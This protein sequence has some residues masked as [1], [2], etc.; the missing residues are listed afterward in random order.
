MDT[1]IVTSLGAGS[2]IDITKL[3]SQLVEVERAPQE[4]RI[5]TRE[6][7]LQ[8][9]ISG[10]GQLKS[11]LDTLKTAI[12]AL[13]SKDLFNARSVAVPTSEAITADKVSPG[14]QTGS[15]KIKV[16]GVASA[17]SLA[18]AAQDERDSA[19]NAAGNMTISFGEWSYS[20]TPATTPSGFAVNDDRAS[21]SISVAATDSLDSI[22]AKINAQD[23]GVQAS[24]LKVDDRYQLMLTSP[25]GKNNAMQ[26]SVDD[27]S[28]NGFAFTTT[29]HAQ[30][31]E[32][33]QA[34]NAEIEVN[35]LTVT[36]ENNSIDDVISGF[37]FT[38]N[39]VSTESLSFAVTADRDAAEDAVRGFI[40]AYND[41]QKTSQKLVGYTRDEDNNLVRGELAGDSSAR[42]TINRLREMI[43]SAVPGLESGF[44]ALTNIGVRTERDGSVSI[45]EDEFSSAI[46]NN[47]NLVAELF[48]SKTTSAN[49]AVTVNPGTFSAKAV[50]GNY[51]VEIAMDPTHG[52]TLGTTLSHADFDPVTATFNTPLT[53]SGAD[54]RFQINV[55]GA[56]S[57][58]IELSGTYA[59]AEELRADLQSRINGDS[60]LKAA[61]VGLDVGFDTAT[62]RFSFT[63]REYGTASQVRFTATGT[64]LTALG[65]APTQA[66]IVGSA[67]TQSGFD[68]PTESFATP[69]DAAAGDY[70]FKIR[71]DGVTSDTL[72]LTGT[73]DT[74]EEL[75]AGL[76]T[77]IN[78]DAK[79]AAAGAALD[80]DYDATT[81]RFSFVSRTGGAT[82]A[83]G[84]TETGADM[85]QLGV[86]LAMTGTHGVDVAGT[87]DGVAGFGA[88][89]VLLPDI[90]SRAYGLNLQVN[91]GAKAQ[92][93]AAGADGFQIGFSRGFAGELS[94]LIEGF[95]GTSGTINTREE[96]IQSQLDGLD[97]ERTQLD[98]RMSGVS[99]RLTAQ[100]VAM[101]R[102]VDSLQG[103]GS[104]LE[105][106]VDR[107]PFTAS[108]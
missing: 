94:K 75:R 106:L 108:T 59:S 33:Q 66:R 64:G 17:Q 54:Y 60:K 90:A 23:A 71:V 45:D 68:A 95:L 63:S 79:L 6:E 85:E 87:I 24:V 25:S 11:S 37:A 41:F 65:L 3:V 83:V 103:T 57:E 51:A 40:S 5:G 67:L 31:T 80:V 20:G 46:K 39:K 43:G 72:E 1:N 62:N 2:G 73:Y 102:I 55:D 44:T 38:V 86:A 84:F 48:A 30:V 27:A 69:F 98:R 78:G 9:Q 76:E 35:G 91:P 18:T 53:A 50:A 97:G 82:S 74:A 10:Y 77:L 61:G 32:T 16:L 56:T 14:A 28:L 21:L 49:S 22:A 4:Q 42:T 89:N 26:V 107:L 19:L 96:S 81:D 105:G 93:E 100:Y 13:G 99:A 70:S 29:N 88:G 47:F 104:Q 36:R 34:Q 52:Q 7:K 58:Q 101:E 15:Y 92:S 8:V 12:S